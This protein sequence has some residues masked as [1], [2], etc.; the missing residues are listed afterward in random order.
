LIKELLEYK[1]MGR[2]RKGIVVLLFL[3]QGLSSA[4]DLLEPAFAQHRGVLP[5]SVCE[6]LIAL[7]EENGFIVMAESIDNQAPPKYKV[8]SQTIDVYERESEYC[9]ILLQQFS[10]PVTFIICLS[11]NVVWAQTEEEGESEG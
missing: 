8:S 1:T 5:R 10:N 6:E 9:I 11:L 3:I 2:L 4:E 7:G